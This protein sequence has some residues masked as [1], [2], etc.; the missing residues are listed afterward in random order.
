MF[1]RDGCSGGTE[2]SGDNAY[3][4]KSRAQ[5][6]T[7]FFMSSTSTACI[8]KLACLPLELKISKMCHRCYCTVYASAL[9]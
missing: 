5:T 6:R 4:G 1:R 9:Q 2:A 7:Y 8:Y 3:R